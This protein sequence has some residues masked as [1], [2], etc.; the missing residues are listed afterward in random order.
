[1]KDNSDIDT[2]FARYFD[3]TIKLKED[4]KL[5]AIFHKFYGRI[6]TERATLQLYKKLY[7]KENKTKI[8][9]LIRNV[10]QVPT[11]VTFND[12][13]IIDILRS[14][15]REIH[16]IE[17]HYGLLTRHHTVYPNLILFTFIGHTQNMV[18][19]NKPLFSHGKHVSKD[20]T[21]II[22]DINTGEPVC[23]PFPKI[24]H[25][26]VVNN[27]DWSS[28]TVYEHIDGIAVNMYWYGGKWFISSL[29]ME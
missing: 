21:G 6:E 23:I 13:P 7:T 8:T 20:C 5:Y 18:E 28:A 3:I 29:C 15:S 16:S 9:A 12:I 1:L 14:R 19:H 10:P 24:P 25:N 26:F 11:Q 2:L 22:I 27:F 4:F 17:R